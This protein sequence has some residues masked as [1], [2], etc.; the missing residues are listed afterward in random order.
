MRLN[1]LIWSQRNTMTAYSPTQMLDAL[2]PKSAFA[3]LRKSTIPYTERELLQRAVANLPETMRPQR[4]T[5]RW[6][7]VQKLFNCDEDTA[8]RICWRYGFDSDSICRRVCRSV[9]LPWDDLDDG[10]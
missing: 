6:M 9:V 4:D 3:L 2:L 7:L 1:R 5:P 8:H 10:K